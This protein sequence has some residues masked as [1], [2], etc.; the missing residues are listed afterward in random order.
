MIKTKDGT[1]NSG[2]LSSNNPC[3]GTPQ[4]LYDELDREFK[5]TLDACADATNHKHPNYYSEQDDA[6]N[7][8][9]HGNVFMNPPYG[10][11]ISVFLEKAYR[12]SQT[13]ADVVVCLIP[14]K[15]DTRW[16]W[17]YVMKGEIRFIRGRVVF[18]NENR[19]PNRDD[20]GRILSAPFPSAIVIFRR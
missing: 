19:E 16:W 7:Q 17:D 14:S 8:S 10:R 3:W 18:E 6:L 9:W 12:E 11:K 20:K 2:I 5:F 13:N 15:T 1:M 4:A